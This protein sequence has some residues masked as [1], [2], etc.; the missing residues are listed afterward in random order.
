MAMTINKYAADFGADTYY[1]RGFLVTVDSYRTYLR[2]HEDTQIISIEPALA[3][4]REFDFIGL[5]QELNIT[6]KYVPVIMRVNGLKS[7]QDYTRD[8]ITLYIPSSAM[9]E[10]ILQLYKMKKA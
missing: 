4:K 3:L 2:N 5:C 9:I 8:R 6:M 7:S 10:K 1:E